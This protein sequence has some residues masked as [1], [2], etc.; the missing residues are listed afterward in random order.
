MSSASAS[1]PEVSGRDD[2]EPPPKR[3]S[4][5][6]CS[7]IKKKCE[8]PAAGERCLRCVAGNEPCTEQD[9]SIS[10]RK[11]EALIRSGGRGLNAFAARKAK[12]R[13]PAPVGTRDGPESRLASP[14]DT[15]SI[16]S[17]S[18]SS[19]AD[20]RVL[21]AGFDQPQVIFVPAEDTFL[22]KLPSPGDS[23]PSPPPAGADLTIGDFLHPALSSFFSGRNRKVPLLH[24]Q[25][26]EAAFVT[27]GGPLYGRERPA[28]LAY[29][30]AAWGLIDAGP[31]VSFLDEMTRLSSARALFAA[32][33]E[34]VCAGY[35][36]CAPGSAQMTDLE[37]L[38]TMLLVWNVALPLGQIPKASPL[39]QPCLELLRRMAILPDGSF[40]GSQPPA[41]VNEWLRNEMVLRAWIVLASIEGSHAYVVHREPMVDFFGPHCLPLPAPEV[42]FQHPDPEE[43]FRLLVS[44]QEGRA[45]PAASVDFS[46][47]ARSLT[48]ENAA[49]AVQDLVEP[50]FA[51]RASQLSIYHVGNLLRCLRIRIRAFAAAESIQPAEILGRP[52]SELTPVQRLYVD[53]VDVSTAVLNAFFTSMPSGIGVALAEG[54]TGPLFSQSRD[55]FA[56]RAHAVAVAGVAASLQGMM[57]EHHLL[58]ELPGSGGSSLVASPSLVQLI[59]RALLLS[60]TL[61]GMMAE[62]PACELAHS[63][64]VNPALRLGSLGLAA[65][66]LVRG[67]GGDP[68]VADAL[69]QDAKVAARTLDWLAKRFGPLMRQ[70]AAN[71]REAMAASGVRPDSPAPMTDGAPTVSLQLGRTVS[72]NIE[73]AADPAEAI[74]AAL[75]LPEADMRRFFESNEAE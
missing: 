62:D 7:T 74:A 44:T 40:I 65:A 29:A 37:A 64:P 56:D 57:M 34:L 61:A 53:L 43:A 20:L 45:A 67:S 28:A 19:Q 63:V 60:R 15:R 25:V 33:T 72:G 27:P 16:S 5:L 70:I 35:L 59:E 39:I 8:R 71:F 75:L 55:F 10:R 4:C 52:D 1:D 42:F 31:E 36:D 11:R 17:A 30:A 21:F 47:Y 2:A 23:I 50:V 32:A 3:P 38:Q 24:R 9:Y 66:A 54:V 68:A 73:A 58:P 22:P 12:W 69:E 18:H 49:R 6:E 13:K 26:F 14:T 46:A 48:P 41:D 51:C